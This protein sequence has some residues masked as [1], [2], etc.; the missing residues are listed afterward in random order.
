MF[1]QGPDAP[2]D[3]LA[4]S[5]SDPI[6]QYPKMVD[7]TLPPR[8]D[9]PHF[10]T[11]DEIVPA[12]RVQYAEVPNPFE[13]GHLFAYDRQAVIVAI[14]AGD[15]VRGV[16]VSDD[17][18]VLSKTVLCKIEN[19]ICGTIRSQL[20]DRR[21]LLICRAIVALALPILVS[22]LL[23]AA[24]VQIQ[25]V[26]LIG[27]LASEFVGSAGASLGGF[28]LGI[29]ISIL[30]SIW[31]WH[32]RPKDH[33]SWPRL[34]RYSCAG[35]DTFKVDGNISELLADLESTIFES[36]KLAN[37]RCYITGADAN[38]LGKVI[39]SAYRI[40][41]R[42]G[43][44]A[45]AAMYLDVA[46]EL[47][48]CGR[49]MS[50]R[51]AFLGRRQGRVRLSHLIEP[52][53]ASNLHKSSKW[54]IAP[55]QI[56][57]GFFVAFIIF[58]LAGLFY[59]GKDDFEVVRPNSIWIHS[60]SL[61]HATV[62]SFSWVNVDQVGTTSVIPIRGPGWFWTWP[63]P[64]TSREHLSMADRRAS[65]QALLGRFD[66]S[67]LD[68][69]QIDFLYIVVDHRRWVGHGLDS[70]ASALVVEVLA[71]NLTNFLADE[72]QKLIA[73]DRAD[74]VLVMK[75]NME[76]ILD[77]YIGVVNRHPDI[78]QLGIRIEAVSAF[79]FLTLTP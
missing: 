5:N 49:P 26:P 79:R 76:P 28:P 15:K 46:R 71:Q 25:Y 7:A 52:Y 21:R 11:A 16:H 74:F 40:C 24:G 32:G 50:S 34:K 55:L 27:N 38:R 48:R 22:A 23:G 78:D 12:H 63:V 61:D 19:V 72:R 51:L 13:D 4:S 3:K 30:P 75:E 65:T 6:N 58:V 31:L 17:Y 56:A 37:G 8:A 67:N 42:N 77:R 35:L 68:T 20:F 33:D 60:R 70:E 47:Y 69:V 18:G 66:E 29:L 64:L 73:Q 44:T 54:L 10:G 45:A 57:G 1:G 2:N 41:K 53:Q 36:R 9:S 14:A 43:I 39:Y 62:G 59:V